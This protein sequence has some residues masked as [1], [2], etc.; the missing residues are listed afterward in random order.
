MIEKLEIAGVHMDIE[1]KLKKYVTKKMAAMDKYIPR[2][3]RESAHLEVKLKEQR[4]KDKN[5]FTCEVILYL[6]HDT[7]TISETTMNIFAAVDIVE[8]KL[9]NQIRKY[10]G[11][12]A[13]KRIPAR[14][15][16]KIRSHRAA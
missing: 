1:P 3:A 10:K 14:I 5:Q 2:H 7:L 13:R 4:A 11:T 16:A 15:A 6:P 9:K 12:H 8:T